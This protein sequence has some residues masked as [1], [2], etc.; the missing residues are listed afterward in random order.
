MFYNSTVKNYCHILCVDV[1]SITKILP[2]SL[3]LPILRD[4]LCED[5]GKDLSLSPEVIS[6]I[7]ALVIA[8]D[9]HSISEVFMLLPTVSSLFTVELEVLLDNLP[10]GWQ[11]DFFGPKIRRGKKD[12][13]MLLSKPLFC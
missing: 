13:K 12:Q 7:L 4:S 5:S 10:N 9:K 1:F 3:S 11:K 2:P 6:W 8:K